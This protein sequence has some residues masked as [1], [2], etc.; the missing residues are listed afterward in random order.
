M[1]QRLSYLIRLVVFPII[2]LGIVVISAGSADQPTATLTL[3]KETPVWEVLEYFGEA[4][5]NHKQSELEMGAS[6]EIGKDLIF[7]GFSKNGKKAK[8]QSKHFVCTSCHNFK[9]EDPDLSKADPEARLE[10]VAKNGMPFLQ[11][12]ALYG[13]VNRTS[14][15][16]DDYEKKYGNLVYAARNNLREAIQL[17]A[18]ECA[19]GRRL[20]KWEIESVLA[21]LWTLELKMGDLNLNEADYENLRQ[22]IANKGKNIDQESIDFVKQFYLQASPAHFVKPPED[23]SVGYTEEGRPEKG[24]LIYDLSCMHCHEKKR[25]SY[26]NLDDSKMSFKYLEGHLSKYSYASLY[27]VTRYGTQPLYGKR[28]YMPYYPLEKMSNQQLED[29]R[30]YI[31]SEAGK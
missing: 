27:Q 28:A 4:A 8:K 22:A 29:L 3:S 5:P 19:Q 12:T 11:G 2:V 13:A 14:F 1:K 30:S 9:K 17:C 31:E 23:R 20:K 16:N 7:K 18:V 6:A 24:K 26:F 25:Y 21:F 10:Y 15:Y